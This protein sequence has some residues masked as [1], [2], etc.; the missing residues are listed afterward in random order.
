[1]TV[2]TVLS[3]EVVVSN[4]V[5]RKLEVPTEPVGWSEEMGSIEVEVSMPFVSDTGVVLARVDDVNMLP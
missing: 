1:M 3:N 2:D 5:L 4:S